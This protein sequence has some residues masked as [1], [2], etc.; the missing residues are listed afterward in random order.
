M[1]IASLDIGT[2]TI[3]M[4]VADITAEGKFA[5]VRDEHAIARL[6]QGVDHHRRI[7]EDAIRRAD[8]ILR[9]HLVLARELRCDHMAAVGTSAL[10]DAENRDEILAHWRRT[11]DID[12]R[13]ISSEEEARMTY[14]GTLSNAPDDQKKRAVVDIGGGSTEITLGM[15]R[16]V[17]DRFSVQ[18][19]A[20]RLTERY[21]TGYP[22][23]SDRIAQAREEIRA[24]LGEKRGSM[25]PATWSAVAGTPTTL[26]AMA[27][28][29]DRFEP[30]AIDGYQLTRAFVSNSV[31]QILSLTRDELGRH[32]QIHP[33]RADIM[34]AGALILEGVMELYGITA[35]TVSVRGLRYGVALDAAR[36]PL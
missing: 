23:A 6:G 15:G 33:Q 25:D 10:R 18:L 13:V 12:V 2:N 34:G 31:A 30:S 29:L 11:F 35:V 28:S 21:W 8:T 32:P 14:L 19:G 16:R 36:H 17:L 1:R 20:V 7:S 4:L 9:G 26:A 22:P 27:L 5:V 24:I 3:L